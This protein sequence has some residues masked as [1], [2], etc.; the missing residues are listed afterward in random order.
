M[1]ASRADTTWRGTRV[2]G[3]GLPLGFLAVFFVW[4]MV[5]L[6]ARGLA[7]AGGG[8]AGPAAVD[9]GRMWRAAVSTVLFASGG[10]AAAVALGIPAAWA[11]H[12]VQWRGSGLAR[13]VLSVSFALPTVVVAM[14]FSALLREAGPLGFLHASHSPF[15]IV[16]ALAFFNISV[17]TRVVGESWSNL[18][19][20]ALAAAS[21]LGATP[22]QAFIHVTLPWIR[23]ALVG[24]A[25]LVFL[26]CASSFAIV[27]ILGGA[28]FS[29]L[30]TEVWL[31]ATQ[32]LNLRG[33]AALALAQL[34]IAGL[35][36]GLAERARADHA[37]H[38]WA[39]SSGFRRVNQKRTW[40]RVLA[41]LALPGALVLTPLVALVARALDT[42]SGF[43]VANFRALARAGGTPV[44]PDG[45]ARTVG[46]SVQLALLASLVA[47][48]LGIL[49]ARTLVAAPRSRWADNAA[50]APLAVSPVVVGLGILLTLYRP[51]PGGLDL[52][53]PLILLPAAQAVV[54]LPLVVRSLV[55]A[56]SAVDP[57]LRAV[58]STLGA[59]PA[60][61]WWHIDWPLSRG[62]IAAALGLAFAVAL[63][64]F[65][66]TSFL[67]RPD[68][69]TLTTAIVRLLGRPEPQS[70][71][72]AFAASVLLGSIIAGM[73]ITADFLRRAR[74]LTR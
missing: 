24:A 36:L 62:A 41:G 46:Y 67:A 59:S 15:A 12:R 32:F 4:P 64:E 9:L 20:R 74:S 55:P 69:P 51:L 33:A 35:A 16:A 7:P 5:A 73:T 71:D 21:T 40:V 56:F 11:L 34:A 70:L 45:L 57:Q 37:K 2:L 60:R 48:L 25:S 28:R 44:F 53:N 58:A 10:T 43:G 18:D 61:S 66:A 39:G 1:A 72:M 27:L 19:E 68:H 38:R 23:P 42:P 54:A 47:L 17:V 14:A 31:E 3:L 29:T 50:M 13:A 22:R 26:Y 30:E 6:V 63:G 8:S 65:G 49:F 52:G